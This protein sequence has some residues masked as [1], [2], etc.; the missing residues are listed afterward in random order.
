MVIF[1]WLGVLAVQLNPAVAASSFSNGLNT[2]AVGNTGAGYDSINSAGLTMAK[3]TGKVL[4]PAFVGVM[5]TLL[6]IYGGYTWMMS[7]GNEQEVERAKTIITNT[8]I[9]MIVVLLAWAIVKLVMPLWEKV[10]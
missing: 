8:L 4:A 9:A 2:T 10:T 7:R 3:L 5:G 1:A 6:L